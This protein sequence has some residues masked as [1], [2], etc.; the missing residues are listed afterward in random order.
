MSHANWWNAFHQ[1]FVGQVRSTD[2]FQATIRPTIFCLA[3]AIPS[4]PSNPHPHLPQARKHDQTNLPVCPRHLPHPEVFAPVTTRLESHG[5]K[6]VGLYLPSVGANPGIPNFTADVAALTDLLNQRLANGEDLILVLWSY[7]SVPGSESVL[8][9]ML[10]TSRSS[11]DLSGGVVHLVFLA[12]PILPIGMS[13]E[14]S[15]PPEPTDNNDHI[16]YNDPPGTLTINP[17]FAGAFFYND[18]E[19]PAV[20]TGCGQ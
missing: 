16:T 17:A 7:G 9:S 13:A 4:T 5:Y 19:N 8:P 1:S 11:Q 18:I 3:N 10:K 20:V 15:R 12:A 2:C 14:K 6:T